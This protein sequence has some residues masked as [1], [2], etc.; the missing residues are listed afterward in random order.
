MFRTL[1]AN[2]TRVTMSSGMKETPNQDLEMREIPTVR[3]QTKEI[4]TVS[5]LLCIIIFFN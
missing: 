2:H 5:R 1:S 3:G 4:A